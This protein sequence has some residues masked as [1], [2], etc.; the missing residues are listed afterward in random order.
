MAPNSLVTQQELGNAIIVSF[1]QLQHTN[2][3]L[4]SFPFFGYTLFLDGAQGHDPFQSAL[5]VCFAGT[6]FIP[7]THIHS[8]TTDQRVAKEEAKK[9]TSFQ[10]RR[11]AP[12]GRRAIVD[13]VHRHFP[14]VLVA[15]HDPLEDLTVSPFPHTTHGFTFPPQNAWRQAHV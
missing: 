6:G 12:P 8:L 1:S 5:V 3:C 13:A 9:A 4:F 15:R 2:G 11:M 7:N 14:E 10:A